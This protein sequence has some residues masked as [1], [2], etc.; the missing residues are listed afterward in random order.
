MTDPNQVMMETIFNREEE[1]NNTNVHHSQKLDSLSLSSVKTTNDVEALKILV[2]Q[3]QTALSAHEGPESSKS[4]S[5]RPERKMAPDPTPFTG[6]PGTLE[7]FLLLCELKFEAEPRTY[8]TEKDKLLYAGLNLRDGALAWYG[9]FRKPKNPNV[10]AFQSWADFTERIRMAYGSHS[11]KKTATAEIKRLRQTRS[12]LEYTAEFQRLAAELDWPH[13]VL[14]SAYQDGLSPK[15]QSHLV[16]VDED[17]VETLP[18]LIR[19]VQQIDRKI[20]EQQD[21]RDTR[22]IP[23]AN[24]PS[25]RREPRVYMESSTSAGAIPMDLDA[26][27][28]RGPLTRKEKEDRRSKNLCL[29]C[30]RSGHKI[31]ECRSKPKVTPENS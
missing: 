26:T 14:L 2:A 8:A 17:S 5:D 29:Y 24:F 21:T 27:V 3:L 28:Q 31:S 7:P 12:V 1:L 11:A 19:V 4:K 23:H 10:L 9:P 13:S 6:K 22:F 18:D 16:Y 20:K 15:M 25:H 30:G